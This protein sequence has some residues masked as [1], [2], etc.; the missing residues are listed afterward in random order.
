MI[1]KPSYRPQASDTSIETGIFEFTLLRQRTNSDRLQM[2]AVLT[3]EARQLCI[4]G[5]QQTH[6]FTS[7]IALAQYIA[8]AFL[9]EIIHLTSPIQKAAQLELTQAL[10]K[11]ILEAGL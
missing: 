6:T 4:Y 8:K 7:K 10:A 5:L 1:I 9:G 11:A 3:Q 2:S